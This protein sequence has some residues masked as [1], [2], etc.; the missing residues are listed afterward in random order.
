MRGGLAAEIFTNFAA[1]LLLWDAGH[2]GW[3][4]FG[5]AG[6]RGVEDG[7]AWARGEGGEAFA[8]LDPCAVF[9]EEGDAGGE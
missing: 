7:G 9:E 6:L 3:E 1:G 8:L 5:G 2:A 4:V